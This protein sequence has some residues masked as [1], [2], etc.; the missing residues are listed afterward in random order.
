[1]AVFLIFIY[2]S[3]SDGLVTYDKKF[4]QLY[5]NNYFQQLNQEIRLQ[6]SSPKT[7]YAAKFPYVKDGVKQDYGPTLGWSRKRSYNYQ[8][9]DD[10]KNC[11]IRTMNC[12]QCPDSFNPEFRLYNVK[13]KCIKCYQQTFL[14]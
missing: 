7:V 1:M 2:A 12:L 9:C 3:I 13:R 11:R 6:Q 8:I 4:E 14:S 5:N 10:K